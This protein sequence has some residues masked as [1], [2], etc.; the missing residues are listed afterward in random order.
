MTIS[1]A[2]YREGVAYTVDGAL[3]VA[4]TTGATYASPVISGTLKASADNTV[5]IG[6]TGTRF[7]TLYLGTSVVVGPNGAT[8]D[9]NNVLASA[10]GGF[11]FGTTRSAVTSPADGSVRFRDST[12][13][14]AAYLQGAGTQGGRQK[15][16]VE[17][18]AT[19]LFDVAVAASS[20][21]SGE[22][23]VAIEGADATNTQCRHMRVP[24]SAIAN[25]GGTVT[26]T[27]GTPVETVAVSSGTL[28]C[29]LTITAGTGKITISA[30]AVSS[31]T[32]TT[33]RAQSMIVSPQT[34]TIT[35]L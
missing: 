23:H 26:A 13:A 21:I 18:S 32:Q 7:R 9:A 6:E 19:D 17:S 12:Q 1:G 4:A 15:T 20:F 2:V 24:F 11:F 8:M 30:N 25:S 10:T 22:L 16:L 3:Y 5:D 14:L 35:A 27:L 31:L 28:T 29:T 34:L 33:L